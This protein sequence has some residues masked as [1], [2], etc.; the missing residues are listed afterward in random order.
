MLLDR[1]EMIWAHCPCQCLRTDDR[2]RNDLIV[3]FRIQIGRGVGKR[4]GIGVIIRGRP[5]LFAREDMQ[6]NASSCP[7]RIGPRGRI[8]HGSESCSDTGGYWIGLFIL[9][10]TGATR[11]AKSIAQLR[12]DQIDKHGA[13]SRVDG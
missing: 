3:R 12:A 13:K 10:A 2:R 5:D 1:A 6:N 11:P 9:L 8:K 4:D 7:D